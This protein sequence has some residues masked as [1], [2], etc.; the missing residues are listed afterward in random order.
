[1]KGLTNAVSVS[2]TKAEWGVI[3]NKGRMGWVFDKEDSVEGLVEAYD[4]LYG[5]NS[6]KELYEK[7]MPGFE[8]R[9]TVPCLWDKKTKTIVNNESSE[10]IKMFN[11]DF[12]TLAENKDLDIYPEHLREEIDETSTWIYN[13]ISNG[14]YKTGIFA[15]T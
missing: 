11:S 13:D 2:M 12:N 6:V 1:M 15:G 14:V 8:G 9:Y 7:A 3:N 10:I 5:L 4:P